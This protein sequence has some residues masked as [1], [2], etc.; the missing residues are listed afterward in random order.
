MNRRI[1]HSL[2]LKDRQG[3]GINNYSPDI[4]AAAYITELQK[5]VGWGD[6]FIML[7][8]FIISGNPAM[9]FGLPPQL[10]Y[11]AVAVL[12]F[13]LMVWR[14]VEIISM[15]SIPIFIFF[16]FILI[17][18]SYAL[19][20]LSLVTI[21]GV[22]VRLFIAYAAVKLVKNFARTYV[23]VI[24]WLV[25][26]SFIFHIPRQIGNVFEFD[27]PAMFRFVEPLFGEPQGWR[28][29]I[30][31][32]TFNNTP[33]MEYRNAGLFWEPGAFA[34]Y[35][36]LGLIF[37]SSIRNDYYKRVYWK[38]LTVLSLGL[39]ST[40]STTGYVVFPLAM[41]LH[42]HV[43]G[44]TAILKAPQLLVSI[45]II[46]IGAVG[47]YTFVWEQPFMKDKIYNSIY[48][49]QYRQSNWEADRIG[50]ILFDLEY[51]QERPLTGWGWH[52]NTR[53]SLHPFLT[54][55]IETGRGN[56]MSDFTAKAGVPALLIWMY[57]VFKYLFILSGNNLIRGGIGLLCIMVILNGECYLGFPLFMC[58]F[59]LSKTISIERNPLSPGQVTDNHLF[60]R[61][62]APHL[63]KG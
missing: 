30:F 3:A 11:A 63:I 29:T 10:I 27:F 31:L 37:L 44:K 7:I 46:I 55:L 5:A 24:Y 22:F 43:E 9:S 60:A 56:G 61:Q 52:E 17:Y 15:P 1:A 47:F 35:L 2:F 13:F 34:G 4:Q 62:T 16:A 36:T 20:F 28:T 51:I 25:I 58:F 39:L 53:H 54:G 57:F 8:L 19:S 59:F 40:F 33:G 45:F 6:V 42:L 18:Q 49:T 21:L 14:R 12:F 32:H 48:V 26:L 50:T 38:R 41:M 23:D